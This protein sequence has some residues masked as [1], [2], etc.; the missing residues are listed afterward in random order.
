LYFFERFGGTNPSK[1]AVYR[2]N[3]LRLYS[4][5]L[6][7]HYLSS[8]DSKPITREMS[9]ETPLPSGVMMKRF[10]RDTS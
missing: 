7:L 3:A 4:T 1:S 2:S 8:A 9:R 6:V 10:H 5:H